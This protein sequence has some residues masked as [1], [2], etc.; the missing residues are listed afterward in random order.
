MIIEKM[1]REEMITFVKY[2]C[3]KV[4]KD[5][6]NTKFKA[7]EYYRIHQD[8]GGIALID[9]NGEWFDLYELSDISEYLEEIK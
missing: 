2:Y 6:P 9:D 3:A 4:I 5:I 7:G 1:T 8:E